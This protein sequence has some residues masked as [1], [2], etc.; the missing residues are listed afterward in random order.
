MGQT[1]L[2]EQ[3]IFSPHMVKKNKW[4][5]THRPHFVKAGLSLDITFTKRL[6]M[7]CSEFVW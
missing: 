4:E 2:M 5:D 1:D 3:F 6:Q 7:R